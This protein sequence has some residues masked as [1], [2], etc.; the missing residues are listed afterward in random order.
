MLQRQVREMPRLGFGQ[1][2]IA[3]QLAGNDVENPGR[4]RKR[5]AQLNARRVLRFQAQAVAGFIRRHGFQAQGQMRAV[6]VAAVA[7]RFGFPQAQRFPAV[8]VPHGQAQLR[9]Q[10]VGGQCQRPHGS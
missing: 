6:S 1:V 7:V 4:I 10:P 8:L 9:L 2:I 5:E 3:K